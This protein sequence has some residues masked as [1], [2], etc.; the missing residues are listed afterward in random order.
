MDINTRQVFINFILIK[1]YIS[2]S[3]TPTFITFKIVLYAYLTNDELEPIPFSCPKD[4]P[5]PNPSKSYY[6]ICLIRFLNLMFMWVMFLT[7][8]Y[9]TLHALI[10][11]RMIDDWKSNRKNDNERKESDV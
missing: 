7:T 2:D 9:F 6:N 4:Y 5:Y 11:K 10:P 8:L 1:C 3:F